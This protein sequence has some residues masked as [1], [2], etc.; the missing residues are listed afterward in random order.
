[1]RKQSLGS[2]AAVAMLLLS[3]PAWVCAQQVDC[4]EAYNG[5]PTQC[6][7]VTCDARYQAFLGVWKGPFHAYVRELSKNGKPVFRPYENRTEYV[8]SE[9]LKSVDAGETF[10][11]GRMTDTYPEFS[12]LPGHTEHSL[13]I[14]GATPDGNPFLRIVDGSKHLSSY[15]LEYLN[16]PA[17]FTI[18]TL[19]IPARDSVPEML[20]STIDGTD[21]TADG[22]DR[23]N[24]TVTL[25]VGPPAQPYF[26]GIVAY[27]FH[28]RQP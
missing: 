5:K 28:V 9:C 22:A 16:K 27:G 15:K 6:L 25:R 26:D 18:W 12:G 8:A 14:T 10:I 2:T 4:S 20:Y 21:F 7:R 11:I 1:M 23:R 13:L 24:V 17:S 19:P 3:L